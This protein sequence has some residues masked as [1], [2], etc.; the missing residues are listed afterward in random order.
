MQQFKI[1][2]PKK[3]FHNR[4]MVMTHRIIKY[5]LKFKKDN[6]NTDSYEKRQ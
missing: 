2:L 4:L 3:Q 5:N 6:E 1:I